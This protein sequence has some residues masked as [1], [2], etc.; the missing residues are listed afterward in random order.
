MT[1]TDDGLTREILHSLVAAIDNDN[2]PRKFAALVSGVSPKTFAR[3]MVRGETGTGSAL[4]TELAKSVNVA[5]GSKV[6]TAMTSLHDM[7]RLDPKAAEAFLKFFKPGDFG[8]PKRVADEFD[9]PERHADRR[10][11]LLD[12]PPPRLRAV[13]SAK[14]WWQ[15][16]GTL[17]PEDTA[18]LLAIQERCLGPVPA[19][20]AP[21]GEPAPSPPPPRKP[22]RKPRE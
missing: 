20:T 13:L 19:L 18:A 15:F 14:G 2:L 8:G 7:A 3:W 22:P 21:S 17:S 12:N 1:E 9:D 16:R 6:G 4:H 5:E 10:D 11:K